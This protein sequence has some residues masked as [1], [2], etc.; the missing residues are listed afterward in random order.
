MLRT[1]LK[2]MLFGRSRRAGATLED[3]RTLLDAG[4]ND[5]AVSMLRAVCIA[6]PDDWE[7]RLLLGRV[8]YADKQLGPALTAL[9][10]ALEIAPHDT[11][12]LYLLGR[13]RTDTGDFAGAAQLLRELVA[14]MPKWGQGRLALADAL[15]GAGDLDAAEDC[16]LDAIELAPELAAGPYNYG[17]LL[18]R[19]ARIDD[20][21]ACYRRAL[22]ID[23]DFRQARANLLFALN[24][25][26]AITPEA[27]YREHLEWARRHAEPL[28]A[29]AP[30][31][32]PP[33]RP[34]GRLRVGYVSADFREH[35]IGHFCGPV[36]RHHAR[37]AF[38][39]YCYSDV[40]A[41]DALT[42]A[43]RALDSR[44]RDTRSLSDE[45]LAALVRE[46]AI[47]ILVDLTGHTRGDRLLAFAR[48][49]A[50]LQ[51]AWIGYPN[52]TG[53]SAMTHRITDAYADPPGAT[54][55]L[56]TERLVRM[57]EIYLPF[58]VPAED[59]PVAPAPAAG[60]GVVTFGSFNVAA[61]LTPRMLALWAR[62]LCAL[63]G[64]RLMI[65]T[66][67]EGR[68]CARIAASFE[69]AGVDP[70]RLDLRG[71][72][73]HRAFLEAHAE[74]DI[75]LDSYP[76]HGTT[77]TAHTLWMGVPLVTLAGAMHASRVGVSM[78]SNVGM[79]ELIATSE[80]EYLRIAVELAGDPHRLQAVRA[81]L[82][83][84]M[85]TAPNMDGER[86]TR[87]LEKAYVRIWEEWCASSRV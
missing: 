49:P 7:P 77:T 10:Q 14:R 24:R 50:P 63:P 34:R 42:A 80:E 48:R 82:R 45:A 73:P 76:Y 32:R 31:P 68:T 43:L 18:E 16:Y 41:P 78:L 81:G 69:R 52:T 21:I 23:P 12:T 3:A 85:R 57:P 30:P 22:G 64:S 1:L 11:D 47:D 54:D 46:D 17:V 62:I 26:D 56:Y 75:A 15:T 86:Y 60:R 13:A 72:V 38:E 66:L 79:P 20:A 51:V 40:S 27:L 33:R 58:A 44:W 87:F 83:G 35:P 19:T 6:R 53:M 65:L 55:H 59:V 70:A 25:T 28:T 36:L 4:R 29:A 8:L 67:P 71:T 74:V 5:D 39:I 2:G 61:K 37:D 84:R 9:E